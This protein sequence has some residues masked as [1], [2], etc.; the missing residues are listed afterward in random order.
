MVKRRGDILRHTL[1]CVEVEKL[2]VQWLDDLATPGPLEYASIKSEK[3]NQVY[4]MARYFSEP[5]QAGVS[6][7][8]T[9]QENDM[10]VF[11][12]SVEMYFGWGRCVRDERMTKALWQVL[13]EG[14][15]YVGRELVPLMKRVFEFNN[16]KITNRSNIKKIILAQPLVQSL[17]SECL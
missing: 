14:G 10:R 1:S 7:G 8:L 4:R 16:L 9:E 15:N 6:D 2:H 13:E 17:N 3:D 12:M 11:K 5:D